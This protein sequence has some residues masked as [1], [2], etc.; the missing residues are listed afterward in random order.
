[1]IL[2]I[3]QNS[4]NMTE[5][6]K[7]VRVLHFDFFHKEFFQ[8][9]RVP[10]TNT[11][12]FFVLFTLAMQLDSRVSTTYVLNVEVGKLLCFS[13]FDE[14]LDLGVSSK[15]SSTYFKSCTMIF[16]DSTFF[17]F[18]FATFQTTLFHHLQ[19]EVVQSGAPAA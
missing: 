1:M 12:Y 15:F 9:V 17:N 4:R 14:S 10:F 6:F 8:I 16:L 11:E 2:K 7:R 13:F 19:I 5:Q 3:Y 18:F